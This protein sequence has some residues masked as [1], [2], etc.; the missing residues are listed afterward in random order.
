ML[1]SQLLPIL[2]SMTTDYH[3]YV[4]V[5]AGNNVLHVIN[6]YLPS[7]CLCADSEAWA[8]VLHQLDS[9]PIMEPVILVGN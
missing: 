6:S 3:M 4:L 7:S 5:A 9:L 2:R 1:V 8:A